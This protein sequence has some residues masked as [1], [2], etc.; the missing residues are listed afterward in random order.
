MSNRFQ[1]KNHLRAILWMVFGVLLIS[2]VV[3]YMNQSE[4]APKKKTVAKS[5]FEVQKLTKPKPKPKPK[6]KKT[7]PKAKAKAPS[8]MMSSSLAGVDLGIPEFAADMD[9]GDSLLGDVGKNVVMTEDTVDVA[10]KAAERTPFEYPKKARKAGVTGYVL[11]NLLISESGSVDR[12]KVLESSPAGVFDEVA[13]NGVKSW[14]F[15]PAQYQ[16]QAVKVWA[17]QK[18]RFDLQ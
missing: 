9:M 4:E 8:P 14:R 18:I 12:V 7:K 13:V 6:P 11:M 5:E 3:Y 1:L 2:S 10:P 17:K 16:G 15:T